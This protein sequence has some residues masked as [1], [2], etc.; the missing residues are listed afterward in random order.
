MTNPT[1]PH[2][3]DEYEDGAQ[4]TGPTGPPP[5]AAPLFS[6]WERITGSHPAPEVRRFAT[7]LRNAYFRAHGAEHLIRDGQLDDSESR[8][9][10]DAIAAEALTAL[11]SF[12]FGEVT[13]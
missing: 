6:E 4:A 1:A 7:V 9:R 11:H 2:V 8:G 10:W 13:E 3:H 5:A 12:T